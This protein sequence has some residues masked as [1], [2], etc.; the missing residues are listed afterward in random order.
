MNGHI[1]RKRFGQHFLHDAQVIRRIIESLNIS[2]ND[3]WVEIGPGQGALTDSL[4]HAVWRLTL[5]EIDRDLA[6]ELTS[7]FRNN[8]KIQVI[9]LDILSADISALAQPIDKM[10]LVGNL[11]YNISTP[12]FFHLAK[13]ADLISDMTFM[14]QKEVADRLMACPGNKTYGRLT[15]SAG[16][17]FQID[18]LFDVSK[19]AFNPPPKVQS[20]VIRMI[21]HQ[22]QTPTELA[23]KFDEL[24]KLAFLK[25]RKTLKNSLGSAVSQQD[26]IDLNIDP[27]LRAE[28][29]TINDFLSLAKR[30]I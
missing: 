6:D 12:I 23:V 7:R 26:F 22:Q 11:P 1:P 8:S 13:F 30:M 20:S 28:S 3:N 2:E 16:L 19:G 14:I 21:P 5:I 10:R 24:V 15:L 4:T 9:N 29:L 18:K 17:R 25:R 27:G